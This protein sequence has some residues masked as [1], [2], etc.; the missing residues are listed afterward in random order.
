MRRRPTITICLLILHC[1][2]F[3]KLSWSQSLTDLSLICPFDSSLHACEGAVNPF[4]ASGNVKIVPL[5]GDQRGAAQFAGHDDTPQGERRAIE[6]SAVIFDGRNVPPERGTASLR[7]RWSG[8]RQWSDGQRTWLAVLVPNGTGGTEIPS[9]EGTSLALVKDADNSLALFV[10]QFFDGRLWTD[11]RSEQSGYEVAEPDAVPLRIPVAKLRANEWEILRFS[12]DRESNKVWLCVNDDVR[13]ADV[14]FRKGAWSCLLVGTPPNVGYAAARGFD[15]QMDHLLIDYRT[16]DQSQGVG[17]HLPASLPPVAAPALQ[18]E[19]AVHLKDDPWEARLESTLRTHLRRVLESQKCGGWAYSSAFPSMMRFLSSSTVIP[20]TD[21]MVALSKD[22]NSAGAAVRLLGA[23]EALGDRKYLDAAEQ[24]GRLLLAVQQPQG[25]WVYWVRVDPKELKPISLYSPDLAP[26]EDHV[27]S[28]PVLLLYRL[29]TLTSK[30]E[31]ADAAERGVNFILKG[32]NPNGSWS[33]HY[34]LKEGCGKAARGYKHAGEINDYATTDQMQ[35][36]L[37]A[38]RRTR[39]A[40]YLASYLRAADWLVA[41][42]IDKKAKGWAQQYDENNVPIVA[43]HFEPAAVSLSEG[44]SAVPRALIQ[45]YRLTGEEK[46]REPLLKWKAWMLDNRIE[47]PD[48]KSAGWHDYYDV[49]TGR[50]IRMAK[51][52]V[53]PADPRDVREGGYTSLLR[54]V[55]RME[56]PPTA[57]TPGEVSGR[58]ALTAQRNYMD[59]FMNDINPQAGTWTFD[60]GPTGASFAPQTVRVLFVSWAVFLARQLRGQ[61]AWDH[62]MSG[63][64]MWDWVDIF[65]HVMPPSELLKPFTAEEMRAAREFSA[66]NP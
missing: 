15:G 12:W 16:P 46:Y 17:L 36:M 55:D 53:L 20:Y 58:A 33:H 64:T 60:H 3:E 49:E 13:Q 18:L 25:N 19:P 21:D 54:E 11:F 1:C 48:E 52:K 56:N 39:D 26:F 37:L 4:S 35:V 51:E 30:A 62:P 23:Y 24:T 43:R 14:R 7:I 29:H 32:Q 45:T 31:Y 5:E 22:Q 63:L 57:Y 8:K 27:Q 61:I 34:D 41:A 40:K 38:Y 59:F 10:Y 28:H 65:T 66:K 6:K 47:S 42:F 44:I 2:I 9:E 50:G